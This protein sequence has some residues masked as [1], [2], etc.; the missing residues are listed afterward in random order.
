M[1]CFFLC[2]SITLI[3][4]KYF[5]EYLYILLCATLSR[6]SNHYQ[7]HVTKLIAICSGTCKF[8]S[9]RIGSH[10]QLL[11]CKN[12]KCVIAMYPKDNRHILLLYF[13]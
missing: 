6:F 1:N 7:N 10:T 4:E 8:Q 5:I 3:V 11:Y 13:S 2:V 12:V 9:I